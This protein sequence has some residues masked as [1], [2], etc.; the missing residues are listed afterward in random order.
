MC[1]LTKLRHDNDLSMKNNCHNNFFFIF[2]YHNF[3]DLKNNDQN[4]EK[5][6]I[7]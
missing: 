7:C 5:T 2:I 1:L 3:R 4:E 6:H